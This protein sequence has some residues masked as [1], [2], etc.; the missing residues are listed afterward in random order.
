MSKN[1]DPCYLPY[2]EDGQ[3]IKAKHFHTLE[4]YGEE[5]HKI[6]IHSSLQRNYGLFDYQGMGND[7][8]LHGKTI[9]ELKIRE[10]KALTGIAPDGTPFILTEKIKLKPI[11]LE[12]GRKEVFVT[13]R[14]N[15]GT[16]KHISD[17][18]SVPTY[19]LNSIIDWDLL[20]PDELPIARMIFLE[21][22]GEEQW[23][24]DEK[25]IPPCISL[26]AHRKLKT[27]WEKIY[28]KIYSLWICSVQHRL[29][30]I[31]SGFMKIYG[32][33]IYQ[34]FKDIEQII[35]EQT[36]FPHLMQWLRDK[37]LTLA[38]DS[39][40]N[41]LH[42]K[43]PEIFYA[44]P[45]RI[46]NER[47]SLTLFYRGNSIDDIEIKG[48]WENVEKALNNHCHPLL[49]KALEKI[50]NFFYIFLEHLQKS[51][52]ETIV[53]EERF[54]DPFPG[55][56]KRWEI[57]IP[58]ND[59]ENSIE[60]DE[61]FYDEQGKS[62]I[63]RIK[64]KK[65]MQSEKIYNLIIPSNLKENLNVVMHT[66]EYLSQDLKTIVE[67]RNWQNNK[68]PIKYSSI[69][70]IDKDIAHFLSQFSYYQWNVEEDFSEYKLIISSKKK[71]EDK[72]ILLL[73]LAETNRS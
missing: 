64:I 56:G 44:K 50:D 54:P 32:D 43:F 68:R 6:L 31:S 61:E 9:I 59:T 25:Y 62:W 29:R 22:D 37:L 17:I 14:K 71:I 5:V 39:Y 13:L 67:A 2:W 12:K 19:T 16:H 41:E 4:K 33:I 38:I 51:S 73:R 69:Q 24:E 11:S 49:G 18:L 65:S 66:P 52:E 55:F 35:P 72:Q 8:S 58:A 53:S 48:Y 10:G 36:P 21:K 34:T 7:Y 40:A 60:Y 46:Q 28:K 1:I 26:S 63:T 47:L 20:K 45:P 57:L 15:I 3:L 23:Q 42:I 30:T 27:R 70:I